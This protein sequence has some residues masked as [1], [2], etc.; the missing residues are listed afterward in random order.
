MTEARSS[1]L[2]LTFTFEGPSRQT[3]DHTLRGIDTRSAQ[4]TQGSHR[5]TN[6]SDTVQRPPLAA[7]VAAA[8]R[9]GPPVNKNTAWG[10]DGHT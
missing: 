10:A 5:C 6:N 4:I 7:A 1:P 9:R 3:H 8:G 2:T